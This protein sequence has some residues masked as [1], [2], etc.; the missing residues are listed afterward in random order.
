M[1]DTLLAASGRP[2][3]ARHLPG[4]AGALERAAAALARLDQA[5][6]DHP[7]DQAFLYRA[8]LDSVRRQAAIDGQA[9][10]PWHLAAILEGL[11]PRME[12]APRIIDRGA[13]LAAARHALALHQ[14]LAAPDADQQGEIRAA[15]ITLA[16]AHA[17]VA[18]PLLSAAIGLRHWL[19][20]GGARP[21]IRAA[22]I[23]HW[24]RTGLLR[25]PVP[26][27]G[28]RALLP[29][30]PFAAES[31]TPLFL[32]ALA[33][34]A[35]DALDLLM[36]MERHWRAARA[37]VSGRRKHSR[38]AAAVDLL[39][40]APLLSASTLAAGLGMA[41]PNAAALLEGFVAGGIAVEV[42]HRAKRRLFGLA[43]LA[44]LR[45]QV[46]PPRRPE[47]GR[48]RGRPVAI[49]AA[50]AGAPPPA[51]PPLTPV[52]RQAI[53]YSDL[54]Q[55]MARAEQT[56]RDTRRTLDALAGDHAAMAKPPAS[57]RD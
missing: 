23:R 27:T 9:I 2:D 18:A 13:I 22:L 54:D 17:R 24:T 31:W 37:A 41:I 35:G 6:R 48:G 7:L 42:T 32:A 56:I 52:T 43:G 20:Q 47:P 3:P 1:P 8:R 40:A 49:E 10:D 19:E 55:A 25:A 46:A 11:R 12:S 15:E 57:R 39:A 5:L 50:A 45:D 28:P 53:D 33:D 34:E 30:A 51:L 38:A 21:P 14:W 44:P 4:L 16:A 36:D 29:D 26:L